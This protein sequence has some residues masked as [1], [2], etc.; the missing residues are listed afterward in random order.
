[1]SSK[2]NLWIDLGIF[3]AFLV[4]FEPRFTG[5][6]V[7]EWLSLALAAVIVVHMLLHWKWIVAVLTRFFRRPLHVSRVKF[8]VDFLMFV[9]VVGVMLSGLLISRSVLPAFGI[10]AAEGQDWRG[11]HSLTANLSLVLVGLHFALN[12]NWV[13]G[14]FSR[15]IV[16]PLRNGF[17]RP[18]PQPAPVEVHVDQ[19]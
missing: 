3:A 6:S 1:M 8:V 5:V 2:T 13:V 12:W 11:V 18:T 9:A 19:E 17:K 15:Y 7:H 10:S 14:M 16:S 4:A